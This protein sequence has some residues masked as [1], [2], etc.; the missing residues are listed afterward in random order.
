MFT[1]KIEWRLITRFPDLI[2]RESTELPRPAAYQTFMLHNKY[3]PI[4]SQYT[5]SRETEWVQLEMR[6]HAQNKATV[7]Y[8]LQAKAQSMKK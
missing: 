2:E 4:L 6:N 1:Y 8:T 5:D 7:F 3:F